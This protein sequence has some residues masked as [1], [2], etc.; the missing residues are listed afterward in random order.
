M[1]SFVDETAK[2][3]CY[4]GTMVAPDP[5]QQHSDKCTTIAV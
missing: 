5:N 1:K 4:H 3:F 2:I